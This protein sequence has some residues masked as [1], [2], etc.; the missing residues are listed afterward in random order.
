[1]E[2]VVAV[3]AASWSGVMDVLDRAG[4]GKLAEYMGGPPLGGP[5]LGRSAVGGH[6]AS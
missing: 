2:S 5:S 4:A 6:P 1:M 3:V